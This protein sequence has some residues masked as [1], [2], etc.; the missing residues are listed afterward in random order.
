MDARRKSKCR[1]EEMKYINYIL[2]IIIFV[3]SILFAFSC[4][5][6]QYKNNSEFGE[7]NELHMAI[8][9]MGKSKNIDTSLLM[10]ANRCDKARDYKKVIDKKLFCKQI[11]FGDKEIDKESSLYVKYITCTGKKFYIKND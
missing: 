3:V 11:I 2:I 9:L 8:Q 5:G 4:T 6:I 10:F 1:G 7:C